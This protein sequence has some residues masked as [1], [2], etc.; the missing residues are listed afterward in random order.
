MTNQFKVH[1]D[2]RQGYTKIKERLLFG[3]ASFDYTEDTGTMFEAEYNGRRIFVS[4]VCDGHAGYMT[5]YSVTSMMQRLFLQSVEEESGDLEATLRLLFQK[6]A[7]EVLKI[8]AQLGRSGT[9]CNVTVIDIQNEQVVV[10]SLGDSPTL[11]YDK[12]TDG[13]HFL[14]WKSEDQDCADEQEIKRMVQ[15]HKDNGDM[16]ANSNTVVFEIEVGGIGTGVFRNTRS[17][18]MTHASFGDFF[19]QYYPGVVTTVPRIYTRPWT[20]GKVMIQCSDG[21]MEWLDH[22]K[23]GIQPQAEFRVHEIAEHLNVCENDDNIAHTLH[24]M[25]I[26]SMY[27]TKLIAH[28]SRPDSRREWVETTFDNHITNV[29]MFC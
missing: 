15:V 24:E 17:Q 21:L 13:A 28:P 11:I 16:S 19:N 4:S 2:A 12:N 20:R 5:S 22:R 27:N 6:I 9:T 8:K 25:Q 1:S 3:D 23:I 14:E 29:F 10:A 26:N 7:A 18:C